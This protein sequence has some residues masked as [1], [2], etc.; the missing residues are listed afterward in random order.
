MNARPSLLERAAEIYDFGS[1]LRVAPPPLPPRETAPATLREAPIVAPAPALVAAPRPSGRTA[2]IDRDRLE[3]AGLLRPDAPPTGLAEEFRIIK[4]QLLSTFASGGEVEGRGRSL[5]VSSGRSADGKT[6][7]ALNLALS[8]AG[9][10]DVEVLLVD[11]DFNKPEIPA[12]L[13]LDSGP[14][15]V[16]AIADTRT[17]AEALVVR[18]DIPGLSVLPAGRQAH[19]V[20]ELLASDRCRAVLRG[21]READPRRILLFDS[22]PALLASPAT[23]LAGLVSQLLIV[24]RADRTSE[25]D[26]RETVG[27]L[28]AC[29]NI[30]LMLNA[31][32]FASGGASFGS[33]YGYGA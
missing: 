13:G 2:R 6:F 14:G 30:S 8:L 26:L 1:G 11:G 10:R 29:P 12:L 9:E 21:L 32:A 16:D 7:C 5:L 22:P 3:E 19:D 27:L 33:N 31:A 28:S 4:R 15:L 17:E 25:A 18:T 24:V 20:T 23:V